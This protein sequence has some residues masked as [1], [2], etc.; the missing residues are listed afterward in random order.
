MP[1]NGYPTEEELERIKNWDY[2]EG[3]LH[4]MAYIKSCWW[5]ADWGWSMTS[6]EGHPTRYDISTGGWSGNESIISA[7]QENFLFWALCW[8]Q[9][10]K[11]GHYIFNVKEVE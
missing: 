4:L 6:V 3:W 10:R 1:D 11:G 7:M 2:T 5:R 9:S 8:E